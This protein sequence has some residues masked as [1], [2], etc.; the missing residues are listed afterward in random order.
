MNEMGYINYQEWNVYNTTMNDL[1]EVT[2][3]YFQFKLNYKILVT[4]TFLHK[5]K[6]KSRIIYIPV[7][8]RNQKLFYIYLL[9]VITSK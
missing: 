8:N 9:N 3:K 6:R 2:L 1:N 7:L 5:L 4:K